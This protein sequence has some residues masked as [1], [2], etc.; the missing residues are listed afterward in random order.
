MIP[1][2]QTI[3]RLKWM[4]STQQLTR[5]LFPLN[6]GGGVWRSGRSDHAVDAFDLIDDAAGNT[7]QQV[8]RHGAPQS[9]VMKS[10]LLTA[11]QHNRLLV[12][13]A[14]RPSRPPT[15]LA[16]RR[17]ECLS[18]TLFAAAGLLQQSGPHRSSP[19]KMASAR[20]HAA[21]NRSGVT[22]PRQRTARP[23]AGEGAVARPAQTAVPK[24]HRSLRTVHPV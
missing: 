8:I 21:A 5:L 7:R 6:S 14:G 4:R 13:C 20:A 19:V 11:A 2:A 12:G 18:D 16:G 17:R 23:R 3:S 24:P 22:S 1:L 15:V 10:W 9:A